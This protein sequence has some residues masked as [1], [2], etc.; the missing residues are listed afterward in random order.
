MLKKTF[1]LCLFLSNISCA[2]IGISLFF[3]NHFP[4]NSY[5]KY[6]CKKVGDCCEIGKDC[7]EDI[8]N[9]EVEK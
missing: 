1:I 4:K 2:Q 3:A 6:K 5:N 8:K 7:E 9:K